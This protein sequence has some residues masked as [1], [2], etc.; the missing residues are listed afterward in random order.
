MA[1]RRAFLWA[2]VIIA[3]AINLGININWLSQRFSDPYAYLAAWATN[4]R[5]GAGEELGLK[6]IFERYRYCESSLS[7]FIIRRPDNSIVWRDRIVGGATTVGKHEVLNVVRLPMDMTSGQY[8]FRT[9][10]FAN[11][12]D[13]EHSTQ[14]PDIAF[15]VVD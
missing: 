13:G 4:P 15:E 1:L 9:I 2:I 14:A 10:S 3:C 7:R 8:V 11:C 12:S 6:Y 5:L